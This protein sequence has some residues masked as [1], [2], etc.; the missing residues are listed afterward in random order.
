MTRDDDRALDEV[1]EG[2]SPASRRARY[3]RP[4]DR[5]SDAMR[6]ALL[7]IDGRRQ[8]ALVAE[9][10]SAFGPRAV[11]ISRYVVVTPGR[12]ELAY[13]VVDA[14]QGRGIATRLLHELITTARSNGIEHLEASVLEDNAPSLAV[15]RRSLPQ[16]RITPGP[17]ALTV[18]ARL[19]EGDLAIDELLAQLTA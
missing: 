16:L 3:F 8:V 10:R 4:V 6:A 13:E 9:H 12:A 17:D 18:T 2:L 7:D 1:H 11:G 14:W 15:L 19:V 5:M